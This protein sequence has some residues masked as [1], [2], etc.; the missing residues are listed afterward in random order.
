[1]RCFLFFSSGPLGFPSVSLSEYLKNFFHHSLTSYGFFLFSIH[2]PCLLMLLMFSLCCFCCLFVFFPYSFQRMS[3][4]FPVVSLFWLIPKPA[5]ASTH[6][7]ATPFS[8]RAIW[9]GSVGVCSM[10]CNDSSTGGGHWIT[11]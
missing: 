2:L 10:P 3:F 4:M 5:H 11:D 9:F 1:M 6:H 8:L 7:L